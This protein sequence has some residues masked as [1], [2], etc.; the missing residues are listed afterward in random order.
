MAER[1]AGSLKV[2]AAATP[3]S[4]AEPGAGDA[5]R[6][7]LAAFL[8]CFD[9]AERVAGAVDRHFLV[10][11]YPVRLRFAGPAMVPMITGAL[12]HLAAPPCPSPALTVCIWDSASTGVDL[13]P[14]VGPIE[15]YYYA[16]KQGHLQSGPVYA[17]FRRPDFGLSIV[18]SEGATGGYWIP[19]AVTFADGRDLK[20]FGWAGPLR[21]VFN[22]WLGAHGR[23]FVHAAAVGRAGGGVLLVGP[24]G[25]GKSTS[26]VA[27]LEAGMDF[28]GEDYCA[29]DAEGP[30]YVHSLYSSAK[31]DAAQL[32]AGTAPVTLDFDPARIEF[33]K[34]VYLLHPRYAPQLAKGMPLRALVAPRVT[35]AAAPS[36]HRVSPAEVFAALAPSSILQ[37]PGPNNG[38]LGTLARLARELPC[39][40]ME[41]GGARLV[42]GLID[43]LLAGLPGGVTP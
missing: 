36:L 7:R 6:D 21:A 25:S 16:G 19:D 22:W 35:G 3:A 41:L 10:A 37:M 4:A 11:G 17:T 20:F 38:A 26:S 29:L 32:A 27:C 31:V 15:D 40:R 30:P 12:A 39:Y 8:D 1:P 23:Q 2:D 9:R 42:P 14:G 33:N 24:G 43:A 34:A 5:G 13:S 18:D 28:V